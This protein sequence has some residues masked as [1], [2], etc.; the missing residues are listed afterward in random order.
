MKK[1]SILLIAALAAPLAT[2]F[3][4]D[5][6]V[7]AA[8]TKAGV[9]GYEALYGGNKDKVT[10]G[11]ELPGKWIPTIAPNP[12]PD[13]QWFRQ[14]ALG[15]FMH[16]GIVSGSPRGEAW[17][18][19]IYLKE[20]ED[21]SKALENRISPEK[22]FARANDFNPANYHPGHW[23]KAARAAGFRYAVLTTRHHDA[24]FLGD[25]QFGEWHAGHYLKKDLIA[26]YVDACRSNDIKVGFYFSGPDWYHGHE[27]QSYNFPDAK[28]PP[29]YNWKH[30][31]VDS[32]PQMPEAVRKETQAITMGQIRELLTKYG[33]IDLFWPDG[34]MGA[35][36]VE[37]AR[38]L[39]P[40]IIVGRMFEYATPEGWEMMKMEYIKEANRR[41]YPW[42]ACTIGH[43]GSWHWSEKAEQNGTG[44]ASL[45]QQLAQ[46]R[47]RGGNLL[48]NIAPRPDGE[49]PHWFYPLCE[50]LAG[51]M[52][53]GAEAIYDIDVSG[54][55][56]YPDQ[57]AQPITT[58]SNAWYV[59]PSVKPETFSQ[60]IVI[61]EVEKPA[62]A[63]LLRT[64]SAVPFDYAN[65]T[66]TLHIPSDQ[67]TSLPDVVKLQ[68]N[69]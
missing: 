5:T 43:D 23:M 67:R 30:E 33:K 22:M 69:K 10:G 29:F 63:T 56:P 18:Q 20:G 31:K 28:K 16:W 53:T 68:W 4:A 58:S 36:T 42:E 40:G 3:A 12:H 65:R 37:E 51:W 13:A 44:A 24:Y 60:G 26:P 52:Q 61:R 38:E 54:P 50:E 66:V 7:D 62:S 41:G 45:I 14:A 1:T 8:G 35:F 25:S 55:F 49:M 64:G 2:T 46:V 21:N 57:C 9:E 47:A 32:I 39:Q 11:V 34:G 27:Y 59:F 17:D 48:I 19:R 6:P 15:L